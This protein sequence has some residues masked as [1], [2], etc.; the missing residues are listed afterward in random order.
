MKLTAL[1]RQEIRAATGRR[2]A[3]TVLF[4]TLPPA[5]RQSGPS[6][7]DGCCGDGEAIEGGPSECPSSDAAF[8]SRGG[9]RE[10]ELGK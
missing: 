6:L 8:V 9:G 3:A 4:G 5:F 7:G 1:V 2:E 10:T